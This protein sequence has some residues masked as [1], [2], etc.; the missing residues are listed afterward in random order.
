MT[1]I[2]LRRGRLGQLFAGTFTA[3]LLLV[4]SGCGQDGDKLPNLIGMTQDEAEGILVELELTGVIQKS[5]AS[6]FEPGTV[7]EQSPAPGAF[8][9][10]IGDD[11]SV[12][13][14]VAE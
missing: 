8:L 6:D 14:V 12:T 9:D 4:A 2:G 13:L 1:M 10:T 11:E 3:A 5:E 7:V